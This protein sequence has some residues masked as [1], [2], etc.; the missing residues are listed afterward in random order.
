MKGNE[1][2]P[3]I[4]LYREIRAAFITQGTTLGAWC[5]ENGIRMQSAKSCLMGIW[6]GPKG[7]ALR[8]RII[9]AS[10]ITYSSSAAA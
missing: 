5:R 9:E 3:S 7:K 2:S 4:E 1:H 10:G 6:N 8:I